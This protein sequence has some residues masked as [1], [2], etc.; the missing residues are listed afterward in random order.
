MLDLD[1][2]YTLVSEAIRRAEALEDLCAP[3]APDAYL[4]VSILEEQISGLESIPE[5]ERAI[6]QRGAVRA[7][8]S[9][10]EFGRAKTLA[11]RFI[12]LAE[13]GA[14]IIAEL[15]ELMAEAGRVELATKRVT[16]ARYPKAAKQY[17]IE[18]IQRCAREFVDQ[19]APFP[20]S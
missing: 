18:N 6:A 17:G 19:L 15:N 4:E 11:D 12:G 10:G 9:A 14:P 5:V 20:I 13:T 8:I 3:G 16:A 7:A 2:L 1:T